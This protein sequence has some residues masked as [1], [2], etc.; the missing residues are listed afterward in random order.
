MS[1]LQEI[2]SSLIELGKTKSWS[3][4]SKIEYSSNKLI[5]RTSIYY[6]FWSKSLFY[7]TITLFEFKI[8][9]NETINIATI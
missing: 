8:E 9:N 2:S 3:L 6:F 1:P 7:F 4:K 5:L